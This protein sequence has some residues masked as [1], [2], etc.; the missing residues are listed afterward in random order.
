MLDYD[1]KILMKE[2]PWPYNVMEI[3]M[4]ERE[5]ADLTA[6]NFLEMVAN[7]LTTREQEI[8]QVRYSVGVKSLKDV[9]AMFNI[10]SERVR[11]IEAKAFRKLMGSH[12]QEYLSVPYKEWKAAIDAKLQ[13]EEREKEANDRLT[14]CLR[15]KEKLRKR[16]CMYLNQSGSRW[17]T[18]I[19][20]YVPTT[21]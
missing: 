8:L 11:Q 20:L 4:Q 5:D 14:L 1:E 6:K 16:I 10:G 7:V 2:I 17:K 9:G 18:S 3:I 12:L 19:C 21:V 13:A 15:R